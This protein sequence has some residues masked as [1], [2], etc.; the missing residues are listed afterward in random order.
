MVSAKCTF[1]LSRSS[2]LA[3]AAA[4][5]PSAITVCALPRRHLQTIPTETPAA[6]AS[7]A[8]RSPAPPEPMINTSCWKVSYSGI[9]IGESLHRYIVTSLQTESRFT[10]LESR[11]RSS[12]DS[13]IMPDSHGTE[14]H[15]K[16]GET[17]PQQ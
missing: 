10:I 16:I 11:L 9:A 4:M 8:A 15:L 12:N 13:Q 2:T 7:I 14:P 17:V 6:E 5:P 1:Q 3:S